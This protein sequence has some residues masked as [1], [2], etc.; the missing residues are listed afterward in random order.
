MGPFTAAERHASS[1]SADDSSA[2]S[3]R[4]A[5][6][7]IAPPAGSSPINLPRAATSLQAS[8][9]ENTPA[10]VR[11]DHLADRVA[12]HESRDAGPSSRAAGSSDTS[13]ANNPACVNSS[14]R[15]GSLLRLGAFAGG[16]HVPRRA[17][18]AEHDLA[19]RRPSSSSRWPHTSSK[20]ARN[21]GNASYSSRPIPTRWAPWPVNRN[22]LPCLAR[23]APVRRR[24]R[25][26]RRASAAQ[27]V[28]QLLALA[29]HHRALLE[30]CA[31]PSARARCRRHPSSASALD[32][33]EQPHCLAAQPRLAH[34]PRRPRASPARH[35]EPRAPGRV[36]PRRP[37]PGRLPLAP[38]GAVRSSRSG[39]ASSTITC[40]L[41]PLIPNEETPAR[42]GRPFAAHARGSVSSRPRPAYHSTWARADPR[43]VFAAAP[44]GAAP[45]PS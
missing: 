15:A 38:T 31:A 6:A 24:S 30:R 11:R 35:P 19:Q 36:R 7:S 25:P 9:S 39:G 21:T 32:E 43:A 10:D 26:R 13:I 4:A 5:I 37:R 45:S 41:V 44:R 14:R 28:E 27:P 34:A 3:S 17:A 40:A 1:Y 2:S 8:W 20:V 22:A 42:R 29:E 33:V 16:R 23:T 18:L 12:D